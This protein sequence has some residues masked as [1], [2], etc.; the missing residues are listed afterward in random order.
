MSDF[1]QHLEE[2]LK[3]PDFAQEWDRLEL[4]YTVVK[5]KIKLRNRYNLTQEQL[6]KR[7]GT[8]QDTS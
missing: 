7:V 3:N 1:K 4:R 2:H 6:A 5:Q 8:A